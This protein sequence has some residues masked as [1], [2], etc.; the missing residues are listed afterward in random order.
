M[1]KQFDKVELKNRLTPIQYNVT[2]EKGTERPFSGKVTLSML[3]IYSIVPFSTFRQVVI[4]KNMTKE[5]MC[6]S[7]ASNHYSVRK[8]ST[9]VD[10]DG[11]HLTT[12]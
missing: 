8:Q 7:F 12:C 2:Q 10:V 4:I 3:Y 6:V 1:A 5:F 11:Q 9:I